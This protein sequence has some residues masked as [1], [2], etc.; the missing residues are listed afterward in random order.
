MPRPGFEPESQPR[1]GWMIGRTTPTGQKMGELDGILA[2]GAFRSLS[3]TGF[4]P[5]TF[6]LL[7]PPAEVRNHQWL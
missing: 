1:E 6:R 2:F 3:S 4:E 5:A 7:L